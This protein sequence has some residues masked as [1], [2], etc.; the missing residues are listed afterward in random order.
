VGSFQIRH[1][2]PILRA[3]DDSARAADGSASTL[4]RKSKT[5]TG[6]K[7]PDRAQ[8]GETQETLS[9]QFNA[10]IRYQFCEIVGFGTFSVVRRVIDLKTETSRACKIIPIAVNDRHRQKADSSPN[11]NVDGDG[12]A[13]STR[14][15]VE[16]EIRM[17]RR[18]N[19]PNVVHL[20][21]V[22]ESD[23]KFHIVTD[24]LPGGELLAAVSE[25]GSFSEEDARQVFRQLMEAL[26]HIHSMG[27][28]H[29]DIKLE[30]C[31]RF[32]QAARGYISC[33][34]CSAS[35]MCIYVC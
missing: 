17:L 16:M 7:P 3:G 34:A 26:K 29:R 32:V 22:F 31:L 20:Y 28:V 13:L 10:R 23:G 9:L 6:G 12:N 21:D 25:R 19:H 14:E 1:G 2:G 30:V 18:F 35:L 8:L 15:E 11:G 4:A 27:V 24:L 33:Q 5:E